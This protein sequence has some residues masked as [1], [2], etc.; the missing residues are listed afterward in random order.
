M[1][2]ILIR[3]LIGSRNTFVKD[4]LFAATITA[5]SRFNL[6]RDLEIEIFVKISTDDLLT[7]RV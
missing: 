2:A 3:P 6:H 1:P 5:S 7:I 4:Y